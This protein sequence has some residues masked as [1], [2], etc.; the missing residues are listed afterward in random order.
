MKNL[1]FKRTVVYTGEE[2]LWTTEQFLEAVNA[3]RDVPL[4]DL[5]I[6]EFFKS[7]NEFIESFMNNDHEEWEIIT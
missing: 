3:D 4:T 2:S 7:P 1:M 5:T 6:E